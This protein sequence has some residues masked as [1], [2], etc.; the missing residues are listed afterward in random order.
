MSFHRLLGTTHRR[1]GKRIQ[2]SFKT[3]HITTREQA[4]NLPTPVSTYA[5]FK[6]GEFLTQGILNEK[7]FLKYAGIDM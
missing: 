1:S 7:K 4:Q 2:H 6:D 5:L 3:I